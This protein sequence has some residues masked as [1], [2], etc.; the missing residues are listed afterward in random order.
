MQP[1][2]GFEHNDQTLRVLTKLERRYAD[3]DGLNLTWETLEGV[4]KHNGPVTGAVPQHHRRLRRA[5]TISSSAPI[6][7][8]E[9]QVAALS[10]DIAYNNHD[11]D[12]GL[13]AGL[14]TVD[15]SG[16]CAAGR[17]GVPARSRRDIPASTSRA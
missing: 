12:D 4:V 5:I 14:F 6:P 17:T 2:G 9:A 10:D 7:S 8:A 1:Y 13:R 11:I 3:F 16:G 15:R